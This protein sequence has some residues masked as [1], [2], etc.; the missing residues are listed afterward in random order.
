MNRPLIV[1]LPAGLAGF[2]FWVWLTGPGTSVPNALLALVCGILCGRTA[3][4]LVSRNAPGDD[5]PLE[6]RYAAPP[7]PTGRAAPPA[8]PEPWRKPDRPE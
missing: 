1:A 5:A 6:A 3:W 2:G 7:P 8:D 4:W